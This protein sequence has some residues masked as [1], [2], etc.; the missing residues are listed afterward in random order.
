MI[1]F[2]SVFALLRRVPP[3]AAI[4]AWLDMMIGT[5]TGARSFLYR[6]PE[7]S[8]FRTAMRNDFR[9][10]SPDEIDNIYHYTFQNSQPEA[11]GQS[12]GVFSLLADSVKDMLCL[13]SWRECRCRF[14]RLAEFR[15]LTHPIGQEIFTAAFLAKEDI[16]SH[17][18]RSIFAFP[19]VVRTDNLRLYQVLDHGMAENHFHIGGSAPA[20][21]FSWLCLMNHIGDKRQKEFRDSGIDRNPLDQSN[22]GLQRKKES[23]YSLVFK[24]AC[25]RYFL[26]LRLRGSCP[27]TADTEEESV[28]LSDL[29]LTERM[30]ASEN[31]ILLY[32]L[33][34]DERL[35]GCRFLYCPEALEGA[36]VPDYAIDNEP[37]PSGY[38]ED[39][40]TSPDYAVHNYERRIYHSLAGEQKL[41]YHLFRAI[42]EGNPGIKPYA[43]LVY[44]YFLIYAKFRSELVQVNRTVGFDNFRQYQDRKDCFSWNYPDYTALR[45]RVAQQSVLLNPQIRALEG[46]MIPK[47]SYSALK[48]RIADEYR[49]AVS[50]APQDNAG[51][52]EHIL[53]CAED[54]LHYVLHFPKAKHTFLSPDKGGEYREALYPRDHR[55]REDIRRR[56]D[57]ILLGRRL[58]PMITCID[59]VLPDGNEL[60]I[61]PFARVTGIDA[62]ANEIG[63]RP[64]VFAP[65]FRKIRQEKS[66]AEARIDPAKP[67]I[68]PALKIT[69]HAG[70]DFLDL[71]D[72]LRA[73]DE[74]VRFLEMENGD[75]LGHA[76]ALGIDAES[77]Y[78]SKND[79]VIL[80]KQ[81]LLDNMAWL[82]EQMRRYGIYE[83]DTED[84]AQTV[85]RECFGDIYLENADTQLSVL[86][87]VTTEDYLA[88]MRLRG[89]DPMLYLDASSAEPEACR[90][91]LN[92]LR[93]EETFAP[94]K[95]V[96]ASSDH[97]SAV[98][99]LLYHLY[100]FC[101]KVKWAG[102]VQTEYR[103]PY[104]VVRTV[105]KIQKRMQKEIAERNIGIET[106]PSSNYLISTFRDYGKHPIFAFN[107]TGLYDDPENP[108]LQVSVNTDDL[109]VFDTTLENEYALLASAL[110]NNNCRLPPE[111]QIS[112]ERIYNWLDHIRQMGCGQSFRHISPQYFRYP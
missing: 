37:Y 82:L 2:N 69:Y 24:A 72:G 70:E 45:E 52:R 53:H 81:D 84:A 103:V 29:W 74:A 90:R 55:L 12:E 19:P 59:P 10:Y 5:G 102:D 26:F 1:L 75:R 60:T 100:H 88:S 94:W 112:P 9:Q 4:S 14:Q 17:F 63:C 44:A 65:A 13:D 46:R 110:E 33:D 7:L 32:T 43:D 108:R 49:Y 27:V 36:F 42:F 47:D 85:F 111:Q 16:R 109:G 41:Q 34:L 28:R 76:I 104:S 8:D 21:L 107:D 66:S 83:R 93:E 77:W 40:R 105:E 50:A 89:N 48:K 6:N 39:R 91:F 87:S 51:Q 31:E 57:A 22:A 58:N 92:G 61:L 23:C 86:Y 11:S 35:K 62:C 38:E 78:S 99:C 80:P 101:P 71:I 106:N 67:E 56:A 30:Q 95:T 64:E 54:K 3:E 96:K 73:I 18:E 20:F 97:S 15:E 25:I 68:V 98:S 79:T